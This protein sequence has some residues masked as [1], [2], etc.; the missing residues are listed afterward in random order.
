MLMRYGGDSEA[1]MNVVHPLVCHLD[2]KV[3][4]L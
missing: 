4:M 2:S 3:C 1:E